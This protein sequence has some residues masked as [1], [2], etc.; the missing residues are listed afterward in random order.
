[1]SACREFIVAYRGV[2]VVGIVA[3]LR[4]VGLVVFLYSVERVSFFG[5]FVWIVLKGKC[6][7]KGDCKEVIVISV[8][9]WKVKF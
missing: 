6:G 4:I 9:T 1:M 3:V 7:V 2:R 5:F 8:E